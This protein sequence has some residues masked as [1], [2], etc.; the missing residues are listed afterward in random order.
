MDCSPWGSSV[1]GILQARILE[2]VA[3]LSSRG[4]PW[5]RDRTHFS[6]FLLWQACS[7]H[8]LH[9][10]ASTVT[11]VRVQMLT[12]PF[13]ATFSAVWVPFPHTGTHTQHVF[14]PASLL[15][16][17]WL[18]ACGVAGRMMQRIRKMSETSFNWWTSR[19]YEGIFYSELLFVIFAINAF[20][21]I[22][23]FEH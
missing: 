11:E 22:R 23:Q 6:C 14:A 21:L 3:M 8:E 17:K 4:S 19:N 20:S 18:F 7:L 13:P 5:P 9:M 10:R 16:V 15:Y 1:H 2:W 12:S